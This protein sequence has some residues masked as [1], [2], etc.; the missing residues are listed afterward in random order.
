MSKRVRF[1]IV[2]ALVGIGVYFI[3]PTVQ[4][5]FFVSDHMKKLA[6]QPR[7][8]VRDYARSEA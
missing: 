8:L 1:L 5:Y 6:S 7:E 4:W 2:L 3:Y